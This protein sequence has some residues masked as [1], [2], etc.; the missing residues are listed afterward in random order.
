MLHG[1]TE[2]TSNPKKDKLTEFFLYKKGQK[3]MTNLI[4]NAENAEKC[5]GGNTI[6]PRISKGKNKRKFI[7]DAENADNAEVEGSITEDK[8]D[9]KM[10]EYNAFHWTLTWNNYPKNWNDFFND[11]KPLI[12][13]I[14]VGEEI[15]P[16]TGTPH[17]QG[18]IRLFKK[19]VARTYL[20]LPKAIHW[21]VMNRNATEKQNTKYCTKQKTSVLSWGI[22]MP[23]R[24]DMKLD[25]WM[26][27]LWSILE[28]E[29]DF[30]SIYWIYEPTGCIG[31]TAFAKKVF[32]EFENV[33]IINGKGN[34]IR[35]C[36]SDHHK[37]QGKYPRIAVMD[38]PRVNHEYISYEAVEN[39]KNMFFYSGKFE[40]GACCG[41]NP[42]M[43]IYANERPDTSKMS[44]DRWKIGEIKVKDNERVI[45]WENVI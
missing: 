38:I 16:T 29:P 12:E 4:E 42:H 41:P 9:K 39:I 36:V 17:L 34:D 18:W 25:P 27:E 31:K 22:P 13:K 6:P 11:R 20:T 43:M 7:E 44:S 1:L 21:E 19:N 2:K 35:H 30:R 3:N 40:G 8:K 26:K 45:V 23:Y 15:C 10:K 37:R 28:S 24:V 33:V 32:L 14:C 5:P